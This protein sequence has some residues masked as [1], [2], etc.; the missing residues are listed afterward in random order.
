MIATTTIYVNALSKEVTLNVCNSEI[1]QEMRS[2]GVHQWQIANY[3]GIGESTLCRK[4]R[5]ELDP[6]FKR[7]I[8]QA[9]LALDK[10]AH[11]A[12]LPSE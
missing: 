7:Q 5:S 12:N 11:D 4:M 10:S 1:K 3:L 2:R 8:K 9:I 6:E